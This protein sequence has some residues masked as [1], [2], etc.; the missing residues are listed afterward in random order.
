M[1]TRT[2]L[3]YLLAGLLLVSGPGCIVIGGHGWWGSTVWTEST[4]EQIPIDTANLNALDVRTHNGSISFDGQTAGTTEAYVT[5]TK[6]AGGLTHGAA[7]AALEA[8]EVYVK[9][10]GDGAQRI[11]WKWKGVKRPSWRARVSFDIKAPGNLRFDGKTHNGSIGAE[12]I[13]GDV[14][15]VTHNGPVEVAE[16]T[17]DVRVVTHNGSVN[18][19]SAGGKLYAETH[20]GRIVATYTGD[21][22]T[23]ETHNG[24]ISADL[25]HCAVLNGSIVTHNGGVEVVLGEEA[26]TKLECRTHNGAIKCKVPLTD[27]EST[28][29]KLTGTI[30]TG[31]GSLDVTTHNGSVRIEKASG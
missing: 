24:G 19:A 31:E 12:G 20:N 9:S 7:E 10:A 3:I 1:T 21:D 13:T 22:I 28:R 5:V 18:V 14:R 16:V 15:V 23:V 26:S 8:V 11:G 25:Q 4:T 29:R 6:K 17:G 30:G 27:S 2:R